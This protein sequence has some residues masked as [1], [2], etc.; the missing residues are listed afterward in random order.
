MFCFVAA[1]DEGSL[2]PKRKS[3]EFFCVQTELSTLK[4]RERG[5]GFEVG[6]VEEKPDKFTIV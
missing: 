3:D 5:W 2:I 6:V 1:F 4:S